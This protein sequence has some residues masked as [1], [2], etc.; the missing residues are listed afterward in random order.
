VPVQL[1]IQACKECKY[2]NP[3]NK[4]NPPFGACTHPD[5]DKCTPD[6]MIYYGPGIPPWCPLKSFVDRI[7]DMALARQ[8]LYEP[9]KCAII[10]NVKTS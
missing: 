7:S 3:D 2:Y 9:R 1:T 8:G 10:V 5:A 4:F 6:D